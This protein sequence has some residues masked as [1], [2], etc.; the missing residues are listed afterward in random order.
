MPISTQIK[1]TIAGESL[2]RFSQLVIDQKI[3]THHRFSL[4]QPLPKEFVEQAIDKA[5]K[6]VGQSIRININA[7]STVTDAP[8][9][10]NGIITE[11][12][13]IRTA[14]ASGGILINGYSPTILLEGAPHTKSFSGKTLSDIIN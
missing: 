11:A 4:L 10:F 13:L 7:N 12:R 5:Q 3:Q 1:I 9:L 14:G 2:T 8:L 6:Y